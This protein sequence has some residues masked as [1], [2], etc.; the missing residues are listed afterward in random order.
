MDKRVV[1]IG[2]SFR[3]PGTTPQ[4]FWHD[5]LANKDLVSHVEEGRW[6]FDAYTHP[7][8]KHPGTS[9][10]FSAGSVG[11][12]SGFDASFFGISP[13]EASLMDPQQRMLLEM[14]WESVEHAG[15]AP[16]SLKGSQCGVYIGIASADYAY[17]FTE[18]ISIVDSSV[19]TGNT[20]SIAANRISYLFDLHGPSIAMD[21]ACSSSMVAFHQACQ[22]I[23]SGEIEEAL[24]G[25]VSLHLHPYGFIAFSKA[26][27]LSRKGRCQVFDAAGDG[28][29]RSEGGGIFY[30]K[31]YDAAIRDGDRILAVVA[32]SGVN[33]DGYKSGLTVPNPAA[34]IEL[35]ESTYKK[36][37]LTADDL[38]YLE[39]HGT[40]TAVGD[41]IETRAIGL[42][43]GQQRSKPLPIGSVKS[44]MGHLEAASGVAGL[45]KAL[46]SVYYREV[47]ATISM[48]NPNPNIHFNEWNIEVVSKNLMLDEN[49]PLTIGI[50][51]FGFG[52]ANAHVILQSPPDNNASKATACTPAADS[53]LPLVIS[54]RDAQALQTCLEDAAELL[55]EE[56]ASFY[57][58]AYN[59][60]YRRELHGLAHVIW[61]QDSADAIEQINALLADESTP[62]YLDKPQSPIAFVYSGNGCQ[63]ETMGKALLQNSRIFREAVGQVDTLFEPLA[64]FSLVAE[65]SGDNG[66]D[67]FDQTEIAQP[68]LFALQIGITELLRAHHIEPSAVT[69]HSVGEVAAA[70]YSGALS[71]EDA[72]HVIYYRSRYQGQ[73]AGFGEMS[74]VGMNE[75][76]IRALLEQEKCSDV[77]V[78]GIN[79]AKG[80]TLAG[81][82]EQLSQ[83]EAIF[84]ENGTFYRRL[85]LNYAFHSSAMDSVEAPVK[86]SLSHLTPHETRLP[87]YSTVTGKASNGLSL[88]AAYWWDNIRKPVQFKNAIDQIIADGITQ[89]IEIGAHPVLKSYLNDELKEADQAGTVLSTLTRRNATQDAITKT[90][91]QALLTLPALP[92]D[93]F[94]VTGNFI[95]LDAYPW[96]RES[97]WHPE[98]H[99]S[100]GLLNRQK[101]H[102]LL[103]YPVKQLDNM[104]ENTLDT[105]AYPWLGDHKVGE[106]V[107]FPGTAY[108]ELLLAA[109][110][111][112]T[113]HDLL[114]IEELEIKQPLLLDDSVS[115]K[116][117]LSYAIESG[118]LSIASRELVTGDKWTQHA[119]ARSLKI[120]T[121]LHLSATSPSLP[122]REPDFTQNDHL[123][124]TEIAGLDYGT[125][126]Q[127]LSHGW[128]EKR[129]TSTPSVTA[130]FKPDGNPQGFTLHPAQLDCTF[131]LIIHFM[132]DQL[133]E[134]EG[135]AYVPVRVGRI[136]TRSGAHQ[137]AIAQARLLKRSP[138]SITAEF[139]LFDENGLH[140][141]AIKEARFKAVRVRKANNSHI[142]YLDYY[143]TAIPASSSALDHTEWLS[144]LNSELPPAVYQRSNTLVQEVEPL[145]DALMTAYVREALATLETQGEL[146]AAFVDTLTK[147]SPC[148][149]R[150]L[151]SI[152]RFATE[153][154]TVVAAADHWV[155][156]EADEDSIPANLIW[157]MM[158]RDYPDYFAITHLIGRFGLHLHELIK[159]ALVASDLGLE[160]NELYATIIS[161]RNNSTLLGSLAQ[162]IKPVL[163]KTPATGQRRRVLEVGIYEPTLI[164]SLCNDFNYTQ[165]DLAFTSLQSEALDK[166]QLLQESHPMVSAFSLTDATPQEHGI[167]DT[168]IININGVSVSELGI[169]FRHL[170]PLQAPNANVLFIAPSQADWIDLLFACDTNWWN[171]NNQETGQQLNASQW[172][173]ALTESGFTSV[174]AVQ[175]QEEHSSYLLS[176]IAPATNKA[177]SNTVGN[178]DSA[179]EKLLVIHDTQPV[180]TRLADAVIQHCHEQACEAHTLVLSTQDVINSTADDLHTLLTA[181]SSRI[182]FIAGIDDQADFTE[183][184]FTDLSNRCKALNHLYKT[185]E[186]HNDPLQLTLVTQGVGQTYLCDD[187]LANFG[188][189]HVADDSAVWGFTRTLMNESAKIE[190]RLIDVPYATFTADVTRALVSQ[191]LNSDNLAHE[192]EIILD[193]AGHTYAP[194]LR[195]NEQLS[196]PADAQLENTSHN[197]AF[198]LGFDMPGQL[199]NLTWLSKSDAPISQDEIRVAVKATGLNFRDV[200]YTLGLLSDEAIENGFAGPTLGLE[201]AGVV[202]EVGQDI[203]GY[204]IGD[205]VVGFGPASFSNSVITKPNAISHI[206]EGIS[207]EAASTIP[208]TFFTVYYAL[209]HLARLE[210]G[211][212]ILI[213]G[214]A[215]GVGIAAIQVAQWLG[216]EIYATAGSESKRDFLR[217]MGVEHIYDSRSLTYAEEILFETNGRGVDIVLNSLAGE[218]INQNFR[219]LKPFGRFL[220]LGKR[221]FYENTKVG[222]RPFRNNISYFG[223]DADQLMQEKPALTHRLFTEMM[224]LFADGTLYPLPY[225]R[226]DATHIV[227][228]FRY[229]QQAKQIGKIVV[230]YDQPIK[231]SHI[232]ATS[233][234]QSLELS[235][236]ATYLVTGGLGGFGLKTAQWLVSKGAKHLA[237]L[238]RSGPVSEEAQAALAIF[239]AQG[240]TVLPAACD[241]SDRKAL[242]QVLQQIDSELPPL[243]GVV[244]AAAVIEDSLA[245]NL[246]DEQLERVLRPK[247]TG[248]RWLDELTDHLDLDLFVLYSSATTLL[249]NPGQACYVAAN[250]WLEALAA[251]RRARGKVASCPRWGAIDDVGFLARNEKIKDALQSRI[252]GQALASDAALDAL[253][254]MILN[255]IT[256]QGVLEF[257]WGP[258]SRFLPS[259]DQAKFREVALTAQESDQGDDN[260]LDMDALMAMSDEELTQTVLA[261]LKSEL[262]S[263]LMTSEEKLDINRSMYDMGLDSLMGV[264]L[265]SAIESRLGVTVSVMA[266]SETPTLAKLSERLATQIK[267]E[268]QSSEDDMA[269]Q[270]ARQHAGKGESA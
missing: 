205:S 175:T 193:Q 35:M 155:L 22:A 169:L 13:R 53:P 103:G 229:M 203:E 241:V 54:A 256:N 82:P 21:T 191:L 189:A 9:Y 32:G 220:E 6:S 19:A 127:A 240:V 117:R 86:E 24:A 109:V 162:S 196:N 199:K 3:F 94:P 51:S 146:N 139:D 248:A 18:D 11:D 179:T 237:L 182:V 135:I 89:F 190:L 152:I 225:T 34:Q 102:D 107:V 250:H 235:H 23:R 268:D 58:I 247:I 204:T 133:A 181:Q 222:L 137:I 96:Q 42:A 100:L 245:L 106:N 105:Q 202:T 201:F 243:K 249:G 118:Q 174:T 88:G 46:Y 70:Y 20:A 4:S 27:M 142:N 172:T 59:Y 261:L 221:D 119:S 110:Q 83:L 111:T 134:N 122:E 257:D 252:G 101:A 80:I 263:I 72:V 150:L 197:D 171:D 8:K 143:L 159:G 228:A 115:K 1:I 93:I 69:G 166:V 108:V 38:D 81:N 112:K 173:S 227:D 67:R 188:Q 84:A 157:Q 168:V 223:I 147:D 124:L 200:M 154:G 246:S 73:T 65:L 208:S 116:T 170:A 60:L 31:D 10:T 177:A 28:Y 55:R 167:F 270:V 47:P 148:A 43:L 77:E 126:F 258:L 259:A 129:S 97:L 41:P 36:A 99:E 131:Q 161:L 226:F 61:S 113:D 71:L 211:E 206:P 219:V 5:L 74:A 244:H 49:K 267:G 260:R 234:E 33:T 52:G 209:N 79:S 233:T 85:N 265:M 144:V 194:R 214:A 183:E 76:D 224:Q 213:H 68:A 92:T 218:A 104:W 163:N 56:S 198:Y 30:L 192:A 2:T 216:A 39:A 251:N 254:Q 62:I 14:T 121:D 57:D 44:N 145:F 207:F 255:K 114:E 37:G 45:A 180:S 25:G 231:A 160:A 185:I 48:K 63:W 64:G 187:G 140:V 128:V 138:H 239:K 269:A 136:F 98:T 195:E 130:T 210:E 12:V 176:A 26:T 264:E 141:A 164:T 50:N 153:R 87:F 15:K 253:E 123:A 242:A 78:A 7:D 186:L 66:T 178:S 165:G 132:K 125:A 29:V 75:Q 120:A 266:L 149:A 212:K 215:G 236:E 151:N 16:S 91:S 217:M 90:A 158:A 232:K 184:R 40:G 156:A 238:S 95:E 17:R 262:A 230:A